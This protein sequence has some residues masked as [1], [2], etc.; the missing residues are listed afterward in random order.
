MFPKVLTS[1]RNIFLFSSEA[2]GFIYHRVLRKDQVLYYFKSRERERVL[3]DEGYQYDLTASGAEWDCGDCLCQLPTHDLGWSLDTLGGDLVLTWSNDTRMARTPPP[4]HTPE[5][6][7]N[8]GKH[9]HCR[10]GSAGSRSHFWPCCFLFS[11]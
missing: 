1:T 8:T 9:C 10:C 7:L 6:R 5:R 11:W 4:W 3:I 2:S